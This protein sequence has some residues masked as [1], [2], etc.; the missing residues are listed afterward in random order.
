MSVTDA[1]VEPA[2]RVDPDAGDLDRGHVAVIIGRER[3]RD[4]RVAVVVGV[5]RDD[6]RACIGMPERE[7]GR[8]GLGRA[9]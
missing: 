3:P 9:G 5:Q 8:V 1:V 7:R 4:D 6:A 2:E